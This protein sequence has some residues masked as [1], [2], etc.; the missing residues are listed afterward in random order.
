VS[1]KPPSVSDDEIAEMFALGWAAHEAVLTEP[2][3]FAPGEGVEDVVDDKIVEV[4]DEENDEEIPV[5]VAGREPPPAQ[6]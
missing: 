3:R 4:D 5:T 1:Q 6:K 2:K